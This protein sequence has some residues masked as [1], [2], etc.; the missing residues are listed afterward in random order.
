MSWAFKNDAPIYSQLMY[1]VKLKIASGAYGPGVKLPTVRAFAAETGVNPNTIQRALN[2]LERDGLIQTQS[3][4]GKF[5]TDN[6]AAIEKVRVEI[7]DERISGFLE[8]M[9]GLGYSLEETVRMIKE[10]DSKEAEDSGNS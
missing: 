10:Y 2:E 3:T 9:I 8:E 1:Q 7:A 6:S 5:V 4:S